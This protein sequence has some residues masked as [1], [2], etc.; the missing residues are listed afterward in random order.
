MGLHLLRRCLESVWK[1]V[2]GSPPEDRIFYNPINLR[3]AR[4]YNGDREEMPFAKRVPIYVQVARTIRERILCNHYQVGNFIPPAKNLE[5]EFEASNITIR[6][7]LELLVQDGFLIPKQGVGIQVAKSREDLVEIE[8]TGRFQEWVYSTLG[9]ERRMETDVLDICLA[10]CPRRIQEILR[11]KQ[12]E[13]IWRMK[14]IRKIE[15]RPISYY[16]NYGP[17]WMIEKVGRE[18]FEERPFLDVLQD[19]CGVKLARAKQ[20]V[21][22]VVADMDLSKILDID[23]GDPLFFVENI[24]CSENE[25]PVEVTHMYFRGDRYLYKTTF[26]L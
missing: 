8:V 18:D 25:E 16:I 5:E 15:S 14:R 12:D 26:D 9:K 3:V 23:F 22:A 19:V 17:A 10:P 7:A 13:D 4:G 21:K 1:R 24:Y 20:Q 11:L 6:K 2:S